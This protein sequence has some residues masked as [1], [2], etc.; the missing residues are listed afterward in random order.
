VADVVVRTGVLAGRRITVDKEVTLGRER[1]DLIFSDD[2]EVSRRHAVLRPADGAVEIEDLGST[3][4]TFAN[5]RRID[6]PT[7]LL[8]GDFVR[9]GQTTLEVE[10]APG[11]ADTIVAAIPEEI[12]RRTTPAPGP[13]AASPSEPVSVR[14]EPDARED[15]ID[16]AALPERDLRRRVAPPPPSER[17]WTPLL[18]GGVLVVLA[19][20]A[21]MLFFAGDD[22]AAA[23]D[24]ACAPHARRVQQVQV[25]VKARS[26]WRGLHRRRAAALEDLRALDRPDESRKYFSAFATT[27]R[28]ISRLFRRS[29]R[30]GSV[31]S[32][33]SAARA[34]RSAA[35]EL[36]LGSCAQLTGLR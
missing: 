13:V 5:E 33:T 12:R 34:E 36:G 16:T 8:P 14:G 35:N 26:D 17:S 19:V 20:V 32:F 27:Q 11:A 30:V 25:D 15:D 6:S 23:A 1:T 31:K 4:G 24:D 9:I 21:Y 2:G 29:G 10:A 7:R 28:E 3:N 18:A 22:F